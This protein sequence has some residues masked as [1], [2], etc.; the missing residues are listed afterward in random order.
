MFLVCYTNALTY[1]L[2]LF[3]PFMFIAPRMHLG[4]VCQLNHK[5]NVDDDDDDG[6]LDVAD[7]D[8]QSSTTS[9]DFD[10]STVVRRRRDA[11]AFLGDGVDAAAAFKGRRAEFGFT[12]DDD[13][14]PDEEWSSSEDDDDEYI[15]LIPM[16]CSRC[17]RF[18]R[19]QWFEKRAKR[20]IV[21]FNVIC[22][23]RIF[24]VF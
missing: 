17:V 9:D 14:Y 13:D 6:L 12:D 1:F 16:L 19:H 8:D 3:M 4:C 20:F 23:V 15:G 21:V 24:S 22:F 11:T 2:T 5:H 18:L 7:T 10:P